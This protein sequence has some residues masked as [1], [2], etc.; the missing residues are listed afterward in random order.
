MGRITRA[1]RLV[2]REEPADKN[3][4]G[5][6]KYKRQDDSDDVEI[7]PVSAVLA[8]RR[9]EHCLTHYAQCGMTKY[10]TPTKM[11]AITAKTAV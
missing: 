3:R 1:S 9:V 2:S 4:S 6:G 7:A 8:S 10:R 5:N 11:A